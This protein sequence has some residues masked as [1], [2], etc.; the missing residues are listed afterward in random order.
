MHIWTGKSGSPTRERCCRR[1]LVAVGQIIALG[2]IVGRK[3]LKGGTATE[4]TF[5]LPSVPSPRI[6]GSKVAVPAD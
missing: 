6:A 4:D 3:T 1:W 2:V 5:K